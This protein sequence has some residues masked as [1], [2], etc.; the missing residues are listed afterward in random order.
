MMLTN[1]RYVI[2]C[3]SDCVFHK[4]GWFEL[5]KAKIDEG[6]EYILF[7]NHSVFAF[8]K[9]AIPKM[10]W[11]SEEYSI[12]PHFDVDFM[13]RSSESGIKFAIIE[14]KTF[15]DNTGLGGN[16]TERIKNP[17][18][19]YLPMNDFTNEHIFRAK[20]RSNWIGWEEATKR[21]LKDLPHPPTHISQV[22]RLRPEINPH[23]LYT[24][25][26]K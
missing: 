22:K 15:Y 17:E 5:L 3:S 2:F 7:N 8:D 10:G 21:N 6:F 14:D 12:G 11:F 1:N 16:Y 9:K 20:W 26:Y 18:K 25:K 19:D 24:R 4:P 13:I 23:P